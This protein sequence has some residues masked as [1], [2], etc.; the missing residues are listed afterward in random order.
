M[1]LFKLINISHYVFC[2]ILTVSIKVYWIITPE[3]N[4]KLIE[5]KICP[6]LT[7]CKA[8]SSANVCNRINILC[9]GSQRC[10]NDCYMLPNRKSMKVKQD[11]SE[12]F[13]YIKFTDIFSFPTTASATTASVILIFHLILI[14]IMNKCKSKERTHAISQKM[15][16]KCVLPLIFIAIFFLSAGFFLY[17]IC[18]IIT[19]F[20]VLIKCQPSFILLI[21]WCW[22][23]F[24]WLME[25]ILD[26][27]P[28]TNKIKHLNITHKEI[29]LVKTTDKML[30]CLLK[31]FRVIVNYF[32]IIWFLWWFAVPVYLVGVTYHKWHI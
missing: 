5:S 20:H 28:I 11:S 27:L 30:R 6:L 1:T 2:M 23:L 32:S 21:S 12:I 17:N 29:S 31:P 7:G 13:S 26:V 16:Q 3:N 25:F 19:N 9:L 15:V 14:L 18:Y 22:I 8:N 10:C 24:L 4:S